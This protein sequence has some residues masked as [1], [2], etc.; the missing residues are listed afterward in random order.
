[1]SSRRALTL[2]LAALLAAALVALLVRGKTQAPAPALE[3]PGN[4]APPSQRKPEPPLESPGTSTRAGT[5]VPAPASAPPAAAGAEDLH[6]EGARRGWQLPFGK[7]WWMDTLLN[8][9]GLEPNAA[10]LGGLEERV[11]TWMDQ[12]SGI[13]KSRKD[14]LTVY[15]Q[16]RVS[17]GLA[18]QDPKVGD[19]V[20]AG[21]ESFFLTTHSLEQPNQ[22]WRVDVGPGED[23]EL[24][25][26]DR[27]LARTW[28]SAV[29]DLRARI[30]AA[31]H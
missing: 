29:Q 24:D 14:R 7:G 5:E 27:S 18:L 8:P 16:E 11:L 15:A 23:T 2:L 13:R 26:L 30:A 17:A 28:I 22:H 21:K 20:P 9:K 31:Q 25:D 3:A 19:P 4:S 1:M 12:L 6:A 10:Q